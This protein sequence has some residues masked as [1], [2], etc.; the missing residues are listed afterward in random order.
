M[1]F[2]SSSEDESDEESVDGFSLGK[3]DADLVLV[4]DTVVWLAIL[5]GLGF[6][7]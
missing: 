4:E 6:P 2:F 1:D 5:I 3:E 7:E